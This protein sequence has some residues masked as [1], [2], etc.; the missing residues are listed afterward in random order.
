MIG[1]SS[2]VA[3][4]VPSNNSNN[5]TIVKALTI[6]NNTTSNITVSFL[7][8]GTYVIGGHVIKANDTITIPFLDQVLHAGEAI[9]ATASA[10]NVSYYISGKE[11]T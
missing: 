9:T 4:T 1:T 6:C 7:F 11:V 8:G 10:V 5:Y 3:Y 2:T